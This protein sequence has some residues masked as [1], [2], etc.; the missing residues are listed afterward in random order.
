MKKDTTKRTEQAIR[1]T[2]T[3]LTKALSYSVD[4]QEKDF[5]AYLQ[6]HLVK[7]NKELNKNLK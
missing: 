1:E 7:L 4:L 6:K 2:E 5:I 3:M